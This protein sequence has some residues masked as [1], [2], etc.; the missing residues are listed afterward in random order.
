MPKED[1]CGPLFSLFIKSLPPNPESITIIFI[2]YHKYIF[3]IVIANLKRDGRRGREEQ[4]Q[5]E[6]K[7]KNFEGDFGNIKNMVGPAFIFC[8][9]MIYE[10]WI[11]RIWN[12]FI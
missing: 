3:K 11:I 1:Y 5:D 12:W 10:S 2:V 4:S 8:K 6:L 9:I 7:I